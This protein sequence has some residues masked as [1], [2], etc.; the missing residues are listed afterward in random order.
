MTG[1]SAKKVICNTLPS[2]LPSPSIL[3][4]PHLNEM[5]FSIACIFD[6]SAC[7]KQ[8]YRKQKCHFNIAR[9]FTGVLDILI[10]IISYRLGFNGKFYYLGGRVG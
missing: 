8:Y 4:P 2:V 6:L 3:P 10:F 5:C 7:A 9:F 1:N